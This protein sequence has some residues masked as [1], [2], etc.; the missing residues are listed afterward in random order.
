[1]TLGIGFERPRLSWQIV[2]ERTN[3]R[4]AAYE[5]ASYNA[6][7]QLNQQTGRVESEQSVMI[8]WPF[9]PLA[10]RQRVSLQVR[11]WSSDGNASP[12]NEPLSVEVGLLHSADWTARFVSPV[13]DE[14]TSK[15]NPAP[16]LHQEFTADFGGTIAFA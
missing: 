6:D 10:S 14:D 13:W 12:W 5:I 3:W 4:Q 16:N 9:A 1:M 11:V 7:G 2:T 15:D 8:D